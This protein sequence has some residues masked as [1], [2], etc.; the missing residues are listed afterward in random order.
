MLMP[1]IPPADA[2]DSQRRLAGGMRKRSRQAGSLRRVARAGAVLVAGGVLAA[3]MAGCAIVSAV[4]SH[5]KEQI[6]LTVAD[7]PSGAASTPGAAGEQDFDFLPPAFVPADAI[8]V[9]IRVTTDGPGDILRF[10]SPTAISDDDC[11][12]GT[13]V[14][15]ALLDTN[16]WPEQVP[17]EGI[18]CA[19]GWQIFNA[20]GV[21]YA[22]LSV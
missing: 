2:A 6:F 8:N 5:E 16:W 1:F 22:W 4:T 7:A 9:R 14:G 10:E 18:S 3:S 21:T 15:S 20:D 11:E 17:A 19:D 12:A 13:L